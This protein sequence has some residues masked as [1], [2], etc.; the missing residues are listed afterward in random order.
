VAL[1]VAVCGPRECTAEDRARAA[2]FGRLLA[3]AGAVVICGGGPGVMAAVTAGASEENGL[4]IGIRP[5]AD[6]G[7][8]CPA[9]RR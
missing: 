9:S 7:D 3:R 1:Q 4:V 8:A 2:E 5:G 6:P